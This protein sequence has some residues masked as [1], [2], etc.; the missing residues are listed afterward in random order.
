ML[1]RYLDDLTPDR[2]QA[3]HDS[4]IDKYN[5]TTAWFTLRNFDN[6]VNLL[7]GDIIDVHP[8]HKNA[9]KDGDGYQYATKGHHVITTWRKESD[10]YHL[11]TEIGALV[12]SL[13]NSTPFYNKGIDNKSGKFIKFEDFYRMITKMKDLALNPEARKIIVNRRNYP[14]LFGPDSDLSLDEQRLIENQSLRS[15]INNIRLNPQIYSR[16]AMRVLI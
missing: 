3:I 16:L 8:N 15:L 1:T 9:F 2:L 4:D 5:A 13:I 11:N 10:E 6:F 12:Q 14:F 7:L